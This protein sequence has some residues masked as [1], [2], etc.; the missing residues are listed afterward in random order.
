MP[1]WALCPCGAQ[2][3][4]VREH[5]CKIIWFW[6]FFC[7]RSAVRCR[8]LATIIPSFRSGLRPSEVMERNTSFLPYTVWMGILSQQCTS[9]WHSDELCLP[10]LALIARLWQSKWCYSHT[11]GHR[12]PWNRWETRERNPHVMIKLLLAGREQMTVFK[13]IENWAATCERRSW[14]F[15]STVYISNSKWT[16]A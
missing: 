3:I 15:P 5:S 4:H 11:H 1:P 14:A 6:H 9:E 16:K 12:D 8:T 7:Y 2:A 10:I 13:Q